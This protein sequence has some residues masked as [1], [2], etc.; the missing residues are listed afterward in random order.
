MDTAPCK[1]FW[2][3]YL[4]S[5]SWAP[6][7]NSGFSVQKHVFVGLPSLPH[8]PAGSACCCFSKWPPPGCSLSCLWPWPPCL[9]SHKPVFPSSCCPA[10][11]CFV[12]LF[13]ALLRRAL[14]V[15]SW[16]PPGSGP[17]FSSALSSCLV[18]FWYPFIWGL[19]QGPDVLWWRFLTPAK[20][21]C[22]TAWVL[23]TSYGCFFV[24]WAPQEAP[25][26]KCAQ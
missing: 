19:A 10:V 9:C 24:L 17:G 21:L 25:L 13:Q 1:H 20:W 15:L 6:G 2:G 23:T 12:A 5:G 16:P 22:I 11:C 8:G 14:Q 4:V 3:S 18:F 7:G 26:I